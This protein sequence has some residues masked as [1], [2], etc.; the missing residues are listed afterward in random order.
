MDETSEKLVVYREYDGG[1]QAVGS[2][3]VTGDGAYFEYAPSFLSLR[4]THAISGC[5]PLQ[6]DPFD[7]RATRAFFDGLV[8]EGTMR[9]LLSD[10][11]RVEE[12]GY[13]GLLSRLNDESAG[14]LVFE[15]DGTDP[16]EGR[17]YEPIEFDRL[18]SFAAF[19]RTGA[20]LP[21]ALD[22]LTRNHR[23][24]SETKRWS[25]RASFLIGR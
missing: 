23:I 2:I 15:R 6:E 8:P 21:I 10:A 9:R 13:R 18:A 11:F 4:N 24:L 16:M 1:Y 17:G 19:P 25:S 12:G 7:A 14:A 22:L 3:T 5:L 20:I